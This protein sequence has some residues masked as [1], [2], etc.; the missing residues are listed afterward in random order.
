MKIYLLL[1]TPLAAQSL[2]KW[3][4]TYKSLNITTAHLDHVTHKISSQ[5]RVHVDV[6]V[7]VLPYLLLIL[8]FTV[9]QCVLCSIPCMYRQGC[10]CFQNCSAKRKFG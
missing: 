4:E 2:E 9:F 7:I 8:C 6:D 10:C 1:T 3:L 5:E